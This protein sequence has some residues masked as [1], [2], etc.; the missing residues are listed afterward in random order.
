MNKVLIFIYLFVFTLGCSQRK[1][2]FE[3]LEPKHKVTAND[4]CLNQSN[5]YYN[6]FGYNISNYF[7]FTAIEAKDLDNNGIVDSIAIL[8]P[9]ELLPEFEICHKQKED[10]IENRLL[11]VN[12]MNADGTEYKKFRFDNVI[13]NEPTQTIKSGEEYIEI[14]ED[15]SGFILYQDYGQGCYA[16]YYIYINYSIS[17]EDFEIESIIFKNFCPGV[18]AEENTEKYLIEHRPYY[19]K[20]YKREILYPFKKRFGIIE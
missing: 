8:S 7:E 13:S 18:D 11:L 9:L 4:D 15:F 17:K 10:F 5:G 12:L 14:L 19:L 6:R 3:R 16:Q 2:Q 20:E 1:E